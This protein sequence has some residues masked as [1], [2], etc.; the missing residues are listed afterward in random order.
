MV[1]IDKGVFRTVDLVILDESQA[2]QYNQ[3]GEPRASKPFSFFFHRFNWRS[4]RAG[5]SAGKG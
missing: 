5:Q 2:V 4:K 3:L 1:G